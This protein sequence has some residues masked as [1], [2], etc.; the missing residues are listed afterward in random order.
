MMKIRSFLV[1]AIAFGCLAS[2]A[3]ATI[4][5]VYN[6]RAAWEAAVAGSFDEQNFD[7]YTTFT[8]YEFSPVDVGDFSVSVSGATFGGGTTTAQF[9]TATT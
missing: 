7:S 2:Q 9:R 6:N 1:S 3:Q 5:T 4:L 8:S